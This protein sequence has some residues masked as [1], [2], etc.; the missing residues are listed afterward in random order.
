MAP[1]FCKK[2]FFCDKWGSHGAGIAFLRCLCNMW[3]LLQAALERV[4]ME[5]AAAASDDEDEA[6]MVQKEAKRLAKDL[7]RLAPTVLPGR[8]KQDQ[9]RPAT[10]VPAAAAAAPGMR[11]VAAAATAQPVEA[12]S[13]FAGAG[14]P[15]A[16]PAKS[17][18]PPPAAFEGFSALGGL[19]EV[20]RQLWEMALLP[21][22]QPELL[23]TLGLQP[24]RGILLHG[25][26]GTGK[27][28][29]V[30]ALAGE[31]SKRSPKPVALFARKGSDCL[32]KYLGDAERSLRLLF[33]MVS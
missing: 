4:Q 12:A 24:P 16:A 5:I 29:V 6:I 18:S 14:G 26:P 19:T 27:T 32:G 15:S 33:Q 30:R 21:L 10:A 9:P 1:V 2:K 8:E 20:K 3:T 7:A 17:P 28:A 25:P 11:H 23:Q 22:L 13:G 31:C